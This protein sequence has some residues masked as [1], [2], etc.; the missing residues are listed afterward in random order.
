MGATICM[1]DWC[2]KPVKRNRLGHGMGYCD[3]HYQALVKVGRPR[4]VDTGI[5]KADGCSESVKRNKKGISQGYCADHYG[6]K[7]RRYL[8]PGSRS[9]NRDGYVI[10]KL[11]DGRVV[12]EHRA[13][14]EQILGRRLVPG[15]NVHHKNGVRDDNRPENLELWFSPQPYGQRVEELLRYAIAHHRDALL[16]LLASAPDTSTGDPS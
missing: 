15:E 12:S 3:T 11:E 1:S 9:K 7:G 10:L 4:P 14:M 2:G 16:D 13:V 6:S 8:S 5:C